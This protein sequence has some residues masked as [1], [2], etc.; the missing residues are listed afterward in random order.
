MRSA[1]LVLG[2]PGNATPEEIESAFRKAERQFPRERLA[3]EEGALAR[4]GDI[5]TAYQ[6]LRDPEART[7]HDRKLQGSAQPAP[8]P[9]VEIVAAA[10]PSPMRRTLVIGALLAATIFGAAAYTNWRTVQ[11]RKEQAALELSAQKAAAEAA[12][13]KREEQEGQAAYRANQARQAEANERRLTMESQYSAVR[14]ES[15]RRAQESSVIYARRLEIAE[16]QR[17]ESA[18]IDED[19]RAAMEARM[20]VERDKQRLRELCYQN[21]RQSNC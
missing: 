8:R 16:Q 3:E 4:F 20:R 21:Y 12:E 1:Y 7:A 18:R 5:K 6:V 14:A 13:R 19:R 17:R 15:A 9:R 2:V 10:D 11:A